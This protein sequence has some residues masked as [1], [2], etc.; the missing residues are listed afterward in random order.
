MKLLI[1]KTFSSSLFIYIFYILAHLATNTQP[2]HNSIFIFVLLL[3]INFFVN[4]LKSKTINTNLT[5]SKYIILYGVLG[6]GFNWFIIM[7]D[8][9]S[10][11]LLVSILVSLLCGIIFSILNYKINPSIK[12]K[13]S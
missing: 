2:K 8:F 9:M 4:L 11:N 5:F 10:T 12:L 1:N 7:L 6:F 3:V 13:N